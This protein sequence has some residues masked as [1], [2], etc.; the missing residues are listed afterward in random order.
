MRF[1]LML[2]CGALLLSGCATLNESECR[3]VDWFDLGSRDGSLG[4]SRNRLDEHG[5]ACSEFGLAADSAAWEKGY[6]AGLESYCSVDNGYRVGRQGGYYGRV[7]P[8][9]LE[10]D[11][12]DAY[13][14]GRE[15]YQ[16]E[17]ELAELGRRIES[18][19]SR[20]YRDDKLSDETRRQV[21]Y[22]L[23]DLYRQFSWLRRSRDRL[24]D[25]W[26]RRF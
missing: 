14:L 18:L 12:T 7:C 10:G 11:F 22:Q 21:R 23:S 26:R 4:H 3:N 16:V 25:E 15:T 2:V 17:G 8:V 1:S 13:A 20:L 6:E 19:E 24:E 9:D 5:K